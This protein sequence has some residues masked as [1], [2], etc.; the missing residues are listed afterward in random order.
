MFIILAEVLNLTECHY[1]TVNKQYVVFLE[2]MKTGNTNDAKNIYR[3]ADMEEFEVNSNTVSNFLNEECS[4]EEDFG[5][6]MTIFYYNKN[7]QCGQF[8]ATCNRS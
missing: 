1:L 3:L 6:E 2:S 7:L 5:I 4:D 8:T